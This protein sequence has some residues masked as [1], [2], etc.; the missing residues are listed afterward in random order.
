MN[1]P[2]AP[3][4]PKRP[5]AMKNSTNGPRSRAILSS[6][7]IC[8]GL[9]FVSM[10]SPSPSQPRGLVQS[11]NGAGEILGGKRG[12]IVHTLADADEVHRQPVLGGECYQDAT[13]RR[14]VEF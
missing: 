4:M 2:V 12:Q 7:L 9:P 10:P 13:A 5:L 11:R 6:G 8:G 3:K 1:T 14:A